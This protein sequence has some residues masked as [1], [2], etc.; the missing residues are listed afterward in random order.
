MIISTVAIGKKY[1]IESKR[2]LRSLPN[3]SVFDIN[4]PKYKRVHSDDL[5]NGLY[6]KTN[7]AK[8]IDGDETSPVLFCDAD[9][10]SLINN[11]L[12]SFNVNDETEIAFVPYIGKYYYPDAIRQMAFDYH[13]YKINSGFM[14]FKTLKIAK[15]VCNQWQFEY[16]ERVKLYGK[17][18]NISKFEYDEYAL[19]IALQKIKLNTELLDKKWND[20]ELETKEEIINSDS[21][22]FQSHDHLDII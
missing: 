7:F 9:L 22:F 16:L 2:L 19:M 21:I 3:V 6:H 13:S 14:Y 8:Y 17:A 5:I 12:S 1:E 15:N 18:K 10:F 4:S 11:P 20:W